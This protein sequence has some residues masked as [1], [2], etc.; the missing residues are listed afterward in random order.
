M[1]LRVKGSSL[2][3]RL[4]QGEVQRLCNDGR[5]EDK[6]AF[7][8]GRDLIYRLSVDQE[9]DIISASYDN[10]MIEVR[11][12]EATIRRWSASDEVTLSHSQPVGSEQLRIAV[13]KDFACLAP[14]EGEDESDHFPH[15]QGLTGKTC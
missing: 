15:P 13:E 14:R 9:L 5:V 12:P 8:V 6:V 2:R 3:F 11:V 4:T 10:N 1:K 7:G